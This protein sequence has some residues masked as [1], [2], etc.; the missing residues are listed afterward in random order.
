[1][2]EEKELQII[3]NKIKN[4][5]S[6]EI[7]EISKYLNIEERLIKNIFVMYKAFGRKSVESITLSNEEID[8]VIKLGYPEEKR[9][10]D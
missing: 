5:I 9:L 6:L 7:D 1:M 2:L 4:K 3:K 10:V 8:D